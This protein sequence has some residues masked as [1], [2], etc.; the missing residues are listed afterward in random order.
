MVA[1]MIPLG[2]RVNMVFMGTSV[3]AGTGQAVIV[4]TAMK[5]ELGRIARAYLVKL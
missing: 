1:D 3:A 4:A 5:T 2:D